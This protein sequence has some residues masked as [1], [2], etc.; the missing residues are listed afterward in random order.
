MIYPYCCFFFLY[1]LYES[2]R[3]VQMNRKSV[4]G[5]SASAIVA[6][7]HQWVGNCIVT[8]E[9][10]LLLSGFKNRD[11]QRVT[12]STVEVNGVRGDC[13]SG[14]TTPYISFPC[15][16]CAPVDLGE[17]TSVSL[18]LLLLFRVTCKGYNF[19]NIS[20]WSEDMWKNRPWKEKRKAISI[21]AKKITKET[22]VTVI[23]NSGK[24]LSCVHLPQQPG[25]D[26]YTSW[27]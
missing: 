10:D 8:E 6:T 2:N 18:L 23:S 12:R 14:S 19:Q 5:C 13:L 11:T 22:E 26:A 27:I 9:T 25:I 17:N 16:L 7:P 20:V 4:L 24:S 3:T 15:I 21:L 1:N